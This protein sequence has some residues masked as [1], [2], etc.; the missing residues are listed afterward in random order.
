M[1]RKTE[2]EVEI[3]ENGDVRFHV[4]G[5]KGP[6]CLDYAKLFNEVLGPV[7]EQELTSEYYEQEVHTAGAI[8]GKITGKTGS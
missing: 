8:T 2:I 4:M 3:D 6:G 7:K 5:M 1:T